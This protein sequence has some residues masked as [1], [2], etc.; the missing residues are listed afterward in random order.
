MDK[1]EKESK[2]L[3]QYYIQFYIEMWI[4]YDKNKLSESDITFMKKSAICARNY[5]KKINQWLEPEPDIEVIK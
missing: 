1:I 2:N 4:Y 3:L 5:L